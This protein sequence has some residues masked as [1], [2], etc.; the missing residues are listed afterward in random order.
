MM[1]TNLLEAGQR[2]GEH[3]VQCGIVLHQWMVLIMP[4]ELD[5]WSEREGVRE[6]VLAVPV[7]DLDQL[8]VPVFPEKVKHKAQN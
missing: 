6:A 3:Q 1:L 7:V 2:V 8:V 5:H 4:N